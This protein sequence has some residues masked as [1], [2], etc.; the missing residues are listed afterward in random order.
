M[1]TSILTPEQRKANKAA[2]DKA[3]RERKK[4]AAIVACEIESP[5]MEEEVIVVPTAEVEPS[6]I[7][8]AAASIPIP[9]Q[10][11][12]PSSVVTRSFEQPLRLFW[13]RRYETKNSSCAKPG[14]E[15]SFEVIAG[16]DEYRVRRGKRNF[17][18]NLEELSK[19]GIS[20]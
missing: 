5:V 11:I 16:S 12:R 20:I 19:D 18:T 15:L 6:I 17:F 13:N 3:Y 9:A 14:V 2:S 4:A 10:E 8:A 1:K 7:E